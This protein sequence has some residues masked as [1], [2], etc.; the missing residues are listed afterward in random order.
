MEKIDIPDYKVITVD[1]TK[2]AAL[3]LEHLLKLKREFQKISPDDN[4]I[5]VL[6]QYIEGILG[7]E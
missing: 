6:D 1:D 5:K 7:F 2:Y 3:G 4:V